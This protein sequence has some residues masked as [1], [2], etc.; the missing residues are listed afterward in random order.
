VSERSSSADPT[1][2]GVGRGEAAFFAAEG[3]GRPPGVVVDLA[4]DPAL[5]G[6]AMYTESSDGK[7]LLTLSHGDY[8]EL[9]TA[10]GYAMGAAIKGNE[11]AMSREF[12]RLANTINDGNPDW[13]PYYVPDE[14]TGELHEMSMVDIPPTTN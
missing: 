14:E 3:E 2:L 10:L 5:K 11:Q 4:F 7:V 1:Q 6:M 13:E 9:L 8:S 12:L